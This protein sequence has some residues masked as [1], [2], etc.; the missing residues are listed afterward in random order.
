[1]EFP[2]TRRRTLTII[3]NVILST[4]SMILCESCLHVIVLPVLME[5]RSIDRLQQQAYRAI[6]NEVFQYSPTLDIDGSLGPTYLVHTP[7]LTL[8]DL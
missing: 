5:L 2:V 4:T 8:F 7:T 1:M 6:T 3:F